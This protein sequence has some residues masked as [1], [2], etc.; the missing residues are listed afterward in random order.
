M[1]FHRIPVGRLYRL[2]R[3]IVAA[4]RSRNLR[5][6]YGII[7]KYNVVRC[8]FDA[9]VPHDPFSQMEGDSEAVGGYI[10]R[11]RKVTGDLQVL[12][13]LG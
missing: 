5:V 13:I 8:E 1:N 12:V 10:P 11:F 9:V 6:D 3:P 2:D 4:V 7:C